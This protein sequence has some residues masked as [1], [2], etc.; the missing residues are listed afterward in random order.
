MKTAHTQRIQYFLFSQYLADG[1][2]ITITIVLPVIL[3][4][5]F[6]MMAYG[7]TI[8]LGCLCAS[9]ADIPGPIVSKRN[10]MLYCIGFVFTMSLLT[11]LVNDHSI[12]LGILIVLAT[13]FFSIIAV[14]GNRAAS[15]GTAA[16][17]V[18]ILRMSD[19]ST[20]QV[21]LTDSLLIVAGAVWYLLIALLFNRLSPYRSAQRA[22]GNC[23]HETAK[24]LQIK[25]ELYD[26]N[27]DLETAYRKLVTQQIIV[28]E[29]QDA[30]RELLFKNKEILKEPSRIARLL[31]VTFADSVDLYEQ[32]MA[33]WYDYKLLREKYGATGLLEDVSVIIKRIAGELDNIGLA[34]QSN[35][36]FTKQYNLISELNTL[37]LKI[38]ALDDNNSKLVLKKILVNL[39][40]LGNHAD[41][42]MNYFSLTISA[43]GRL[44]SRSDYSKFVSHMEIDSTVLKNNLTLRSGIFRHAV[45]MTITCLAG[46]I[47]SKTIPYGHHSYWILLTI[48][49]ILKP[50]FSLTKERNIERFA[51]TMAGGLLGLVL[52]HFIHDRNLLF[53]L[54]IFFMLGTYTFMRLNY[55]VMVIFTTPYV[56]ILFNLLGLGFLK[57]AEER[58]LDTGIACV[59]SLLAGYLLF[60]HWESLQIESYMKEVLKAN[61][62]YMK[63][64][65]GFLMGQ[66]ISTL[67]YKLAR[68]EVYV[69]TA[70]LSAAFNRM[71]SEPK[72]K[73]RNGKLIYEFLVL[74]HVLSSNIASLSADMLQ[75]KQKL[76]PKENILQVKRALGCLDESLQQMDKSFTSEIENPMIHVHSNEQ[77]DKNLSNQ[78]DFIYKVTQDIQKV[79]KYIAT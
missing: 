4:A 33:T 19:K 63:K 9:I 49:I 35:N 42:L 24:F 79:T 77:S 59:L 29:S 52:L 20:P 43:K 13:F 8:A 62:R 38:D 53:G 6:G 7:L 57:V 69:S 12:L 61:I 26:I 37:K 51:G 48:I 74:N 56:L 46:Y 32:V 21:A 36:S 5:Q 30:A 73:Q 14:F 10:G 72:T 31:V 1:F 54:I 68:K 66:T 28:S 45:R 2:R 60:P 16:L 22:L 75:K 70:N 40:N 3:F 55:I 67:E 64:L 78:L 58:L 41:E 18:M 25:S 34:I 76:Y 23:I 44:R 17:L 65:S 27:T 11:G 50:G 47:V 71:L 39:R 15:V